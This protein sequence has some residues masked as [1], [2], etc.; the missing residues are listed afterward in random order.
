MLI[1]GVRLNVHV[2]VHTQ[3]SLCVQFIVHM[4]S[5]YFHFY[6]FIIGYSYIC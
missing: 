3:V 2:Q 6:F 1:H 5:M 4:K